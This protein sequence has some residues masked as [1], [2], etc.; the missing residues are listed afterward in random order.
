[1]YAVLS[2][3]RY[4]TAGYVIGRALQATLQVYLAGDRFLDVGLPELLVYKQAQKYTKSKYS[5]ALLHTPQPPPSLLLIFN[6]NYRT[7]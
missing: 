7:Q 1:M 2:G 5:S 4:C 6:A 3:P